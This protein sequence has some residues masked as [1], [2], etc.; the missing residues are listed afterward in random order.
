MTPF[1]QIDGLREQIVEV[2][3]DVVYDALKEKCGVLIATGDSN[4]EDLRRALRN[5]VTP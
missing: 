5:Y 3:F 4:A 2:M 1:Q